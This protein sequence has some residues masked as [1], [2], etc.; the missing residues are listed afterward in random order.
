MRRTKSNWCEH[1]FRQTNWLKNMIT[2]TKLKTLSSTMLHGI[3][4]IYAGNTCASHIHFIFVIVI[5]CFFLYLFHC[6]S[7]KLLK[8]NNIKQAT[9]T[10]CKK[11]P[12]NGGRNMYQPAEEKAD[13]WAHQKLSSK[14]A[15]ARI[16]KHSGQ[17]ATR[18]K[19]CCLKKSVARAVSNSM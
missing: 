16:H 3:R 18:L 4:I 11:K 14:L 13:G 8:P 6:I 10:N 5:F 12:H 15:T 17:D 2:K 19:D 9:S 1:Q 7:S